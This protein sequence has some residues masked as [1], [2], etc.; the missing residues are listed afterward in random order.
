MQRY[1]RRLRV[2]TKTVDLKMLDGA[3]DLIIW[4]WIHKVLLKLGEGGM[5]SDESEVDK[6]TEMNVY[7]VKTLPW[8]RNL[9]VVMG[10]IDKQ[11]LKDKDLYSPQ[12]AKPGLRLRGV[13][14]IES[15]RDV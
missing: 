14:Y 8:R 4:E 2:V 5:S 13:R 1:Y 3:D 10:M 15:K 9:D 7:H 12:G 11:R 6:N